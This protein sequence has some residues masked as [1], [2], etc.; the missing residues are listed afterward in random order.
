MK[1]PIQEATS[2]L[3]PVAKLLGMVSTRPS[4]LPNGGAVLSCREGKRSFPMAKLQGAFASPSLQGFS[5]EESF[6]T[7]TPAK[8]HYHGRVPVVLAS[9]YFVS[10]TSEEVRSYEICLLSEFGQMLLSRTL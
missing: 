7:V 10:D 1:I 9:L 4:V 6:V 2:I 3:T 8:S 5:L